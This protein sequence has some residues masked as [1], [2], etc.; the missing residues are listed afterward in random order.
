[1]SNEIIK[2]IDAL[3]AKFGIA[4]DWTSANVLPYLETLCGKY[5]DYEI[6]TS[7]VW[8]VI[9]VLM[10]VGAVGSCKIFRLSLKK[11]DE[12]TMN[13]EVYETIATVSFLGMIC[14]CWHINYM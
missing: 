8:I 6:M 4:V 1:M 14:D 9:G 11:I 12:D 13:E 2:V 5:V 3:A 10:L 7:A